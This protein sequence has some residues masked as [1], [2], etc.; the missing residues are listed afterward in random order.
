[1]PPRVGVLGAEHGADLV[2]ALKVRAGRQHLLVELRRL[3]EAA[4]AA[5]VRQLEDRR[6]ALRRA[7]QKL[8]RVDAHEVLRVEVRRE[9]QRDRGANPHDGL[10]RGRPQVH[11]AVVQARVEAHGDLALLGVVL[12]PRR[13]DDLERQVRHGLGDDEALLD[14]ELHVAL[15]AGRHGRRR[16]GRLDVDDGLGRNLACAGK[17]RADQAAE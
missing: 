9:E 3:R 11:D 1:M 17:F 4:V 6:A 7:R 13:V 8:G 2:D 10:V 12:V 14:R 16:D 5:K 15:R